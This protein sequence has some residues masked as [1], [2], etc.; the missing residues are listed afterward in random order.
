MP[1]KN[2]YGK[3]KND[4]YLTYAFR[5]NKYN[6]T[7]DAKATL[8][9]AHPV[10]R[11]VYNATIFFIKQRDDERFEAKKNVRELPRSYEKQELRELVYARRRE[12]HQLRV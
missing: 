4:D 10:F 2:L 1:S 5:V 7:Q 8:I 12:S 9:D 11:Q 6:L 3:E